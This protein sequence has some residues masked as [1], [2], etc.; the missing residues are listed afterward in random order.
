MQGQY[1]LSYYPH[2]AMRDNRF[3]RIEVNL[4]RPHNRKLR[5]HPLRE[6][7]TLNSTEY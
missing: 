4:S 6:G 3:H 7:Y 2:D 5:V 1:L